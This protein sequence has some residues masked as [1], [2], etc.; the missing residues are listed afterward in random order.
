MIISLY[1]QI[2]IKLNGTLQFTIYTMYF[3]TI[4]LRK[5]IIK[6]FVLKP[7]FFFFKFSA[8]SISRFVLLRLLKTMYPEMEFIKSM[9]I[10]SAMDTPNN[11]GYVVV[12]LKVIGD[13]DINL[14]KHTIQVRSSLTLFDGYKMW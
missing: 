14:M 2:L 7:D 4:Q 8:T 10:R 3:K 1:R 13:Y 11:I 6:M 12:L 5:I 9:S